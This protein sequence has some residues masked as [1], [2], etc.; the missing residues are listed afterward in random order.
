MINEIQR[1]IGIV[2]QGRHLSRAQTG[3]VFQ[4]IMSGGATPAQIAALLIALRMK[5]ESVGEL[6]GAAMAMRAKMET[7]DIAGDIIDVCGT[8]GDG[9]GMLNVSTAVSLVVAA[10]GVKVAKHGNKSVSSRSGS[11]DVLSSLG[12]NIQAEKPNVEK[13]LRETGICFLFAPLYH[14]SLRHVGPVRQ[15]LATRTLFNLLGPLAN[16]ANPALQLLGVYDRALLLPVAQVLKSLGSKRAWVVHGSDGADELTLTGVSYVAELKDGVVTTFEITPADAGLEACEADALDGGSPNNNAK[17]LSLLLAGKKSAYRDIVLLN[18]AAA[19]I[20]AGKAQSLANG[21]E[22][23]AA[24]ID[25]GRA[26]EV[27]ASLVSISNETR[28]HE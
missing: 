1:F 9:S 13:A 6:A 18:A 5:G 23:A 24:A 10:C 26:R 17:E 3:R 16:P 4:I 21:A 25:E 28:P 8:G 14:K 2:A 19:L 12:V 11:A 22:L 27:L 15:E 20:V 7:I